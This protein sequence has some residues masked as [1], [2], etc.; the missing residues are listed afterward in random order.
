M[1]MRDADRLVEDVRRLAVNQVEL[2]SHSL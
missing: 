1:A 2:G